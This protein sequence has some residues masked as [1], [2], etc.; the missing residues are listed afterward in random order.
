M[1]VRQVTTKTSRPMFKTILATRSLSPSPAGHLG[2]GRA[3]RARRCVAWLAN[4]AG[5][6]RRQAIESDDVGWAH[7]IRRT[8][9]DVARENSL[10]GSEVN[11]HGNVRAVGRAF[12][13]GPDHQ[14]R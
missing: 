10:V 13:A 2:A 7:A 6:D 12:A 1:H 9:A 3:Q 4:Q 8:C 14:R 5:Q 11:R